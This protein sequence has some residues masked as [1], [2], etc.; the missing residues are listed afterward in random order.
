M[1]LVNQNYGKQLENKLINNSYY[2]YP[3]YFI[4]KQRECIFR[5]HAKEDMPT[6]TV[7]M[8]W[9]NV[10]ICEKTTELIDLSRRR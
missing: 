4:S 2:S 9:I 6:H 8:E 10:D 1:H 5:V 7:T 3:W